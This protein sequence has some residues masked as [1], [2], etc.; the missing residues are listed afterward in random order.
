MKFGHLKIPHTTKGDIGGAV[1]RPDGLE[2]HPDFHKELFGAIHKN[3][4]TAAS[5]GN[6]ETV[7]RIEHIQNKLNDA[8]TTDTEKLEKKR[9]LI[10][11]KRKKLE[12]GT[13]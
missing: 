1:A 2:A 6:P 5:A 11:N 3:L 12:N 13:I 7:E 4:K 10:E 8:S 9:E